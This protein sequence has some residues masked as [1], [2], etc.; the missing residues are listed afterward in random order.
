MQQKPFEH[1]SN[2]YLDEMETTCSV[3]VEGTVVIKAPPIS[4]SKK[5]SGSSHEET[6]TNSYVNFNSDLYSTDDI[7][8]DFIPKVNFNLLN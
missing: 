8:S 4:F 3:S 1:H 5:Q 6:T 7:Q 2:G